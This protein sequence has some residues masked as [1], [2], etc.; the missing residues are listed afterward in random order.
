MIQC[1]E[2]GNDFKGY[3][4]HSCGY[5][6][7]KGSVPPNAE[8]L[9]AR[10]DADKKAH[11][12][13]LDWLTNKGIIHPKMTTG[14]RMKAL[15]E[16]RKKLIHSPKPDPLDWARSIIKDY[17]AGTYKFTYGYKM[18]CEALKVEPSQ[19]ETSW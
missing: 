7:P 15:A 5:V 3:K 12:D 18:A 1:P 4:C 10:I 14:E 6:V 2:C 9:M 16:Y 17:E 19:V 13:A 8:V 11:K